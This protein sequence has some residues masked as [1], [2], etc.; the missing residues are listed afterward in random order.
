MDL[1]GIFGIVAIVLGVLLLIPLIVGAVF[2]VVV[3]ANRAEPD[4]SGRR[5]ALVYSLGTAFITL[6]VTLFATTAFVAQL[7]R[8]IGSHGSAARAGATRRSSPQAAVSLLD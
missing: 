7:C 8:L 1:G 3:V 6:F 4:P 2:V 5:P